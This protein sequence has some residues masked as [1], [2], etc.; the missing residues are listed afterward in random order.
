MERLIFHVDVNSAFL[1]WE[2][3][4]RVKNGDADLRLVPSCIGGDPNTRRGVVLAKSIP[5]KQFGVKT[6]EP[7]S[8]ALR[9]CPGLIIA[10]PD[11]RLYAAQSRA[12]KAIC[13]EYTSIV[14]EFSIDE[15]FLDLSGTERVYPDPIALAH[16]IK[17]RI[18]DELGF[19]VNI[20]VGRTK[21]CAKMASDFE[22]PDRVHTLFPDELSEKLWPLPA[23]ELLYVGRATADKLNRVGIRTIGDLAKADPAWLRPLLGEKTAA[24][25]IAY[26]NGIDASPVRDAPE[27]AKGYSLSLIHI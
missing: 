4:R 19:T 8:A 9:K 23:G 21:L 10:P 2:A 26:A 3:V 17:D 14:E 20:G 1:S 27:E 6:G 22:K 13:R 15:C 24:Q 7:L 12:F 11:F 5:A 25:A 16:T 18:K